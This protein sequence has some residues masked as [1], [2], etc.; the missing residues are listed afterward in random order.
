[1]ENYIPLETCLIDNWSYELAVSLLRVSDCEINVNNKFLNFYDELSIKEDRFEYSIYALSNIIN[2]LVFYDELF[3]VEN[4]Y[5][6]S[7]TKENIFNKYISLMDT[8]FIKDKGQYDDVSFVELLLNIQTE[9][10]CDVIVS[11]Y[12]AGYFEEFDLK[13]SFSL[14]EDFF[15]AFNKSI[16]LPVEN[17]S[18]DILKKGILGNLVLPSITNY[19]LSQS[20]NVST[21]LD[22]A[23]QLKND[24]EIKNIKRILQESYYE[25]LSNSSLQTY[26]ELLKKS[27]KEINLSLQKIGLSNPNTDRPTT[28]GINILIFSISYS[29]SSLK[30]KDGLS[31]FFNK[32]SEVQLEYNSLR[33]NIE[34]LFNVKHNSIV[35]KNKLAEIDDPIETNNRRV[36]DSFRKY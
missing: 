22:T 30:K 19:V 34:R 16:S 8:K 1:M 4:G 29:F 21:I 9:K 11:P 27:Q 13:P 14:V 15:N 18:S 23:I 2:C 20:D 35:Y 24:N 5:E 12:R 32:Q 25:M 36:F 6:E 10:R 17:I 33:K 28:V 26:E 31:I 7:W 3:Y